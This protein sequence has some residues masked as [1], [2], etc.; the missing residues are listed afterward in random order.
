MA[1]LIDVAR[2]AGVSRSTASNVFNSPEIVRPQLRQRVE[3]AAL[4]LGYLGPDPKG[5]LLRGGRFNAIG[6]VAPRVLGI[7]EAVS[8]PVLQVFL[9]G[10]GEVCDET[11]A[12]LALLSGRAEHGSIAT[13]LVDG[14]IFGQIEHLKQVEPAQLRR[15]PFVVVDFDAGPH[16]SSV[17]VDSRAGAFAAARHLL[18]L[19]HRRFAIMSFGATG[20]K[21]RLHPAGQ[22]RPPQA[23][24]LPTDEQKYL[25]YADALAEAGIAIGDVTMV[26]AGPSDP[27][28]AGM[29]LD[30]AP[31]ATAILSM[32]VMQAI[33]LLAEAKRRDIAIPHA[34]SV[35]GFNDIPE[36]ALADPPLTT[37][38]TMAMLKGRIAAQVVSETDGPRHEIIQPQLL[39]RGSTARAPAGFAR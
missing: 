31:E 35:V 6:V 36:A 9:K 32:S 39:L 4:E 3:A 13:A 15:S 22:P 12:T 38:D 16:I 34:L 33:S 24:G 20:S 19:G 1:R 10:V 18:D 25:G 14:F 11:G 30:A 5:R 17:R 7:A 2:R 21:A 27:E 26:Q 29:I 8:N 28:A 23:A 37:V